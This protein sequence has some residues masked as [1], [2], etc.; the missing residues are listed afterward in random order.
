ME[1]AHLLGLTVQAEGDRL[2]VRGRPTPE[3]ETL[4][5]KLMASKLAV[6]TALA[7]RGQT[8][9]PCGWFCAEPG[10]G[11]PCKVVRGETTLEEYLAERYP[12]TA[13]ADRKEALA[14]FYGHACGL[15]RQARD[16]GLLKPAPP[17]TC[18]HQGAQTEAQRGGRVRPQDDPGFC[19]CCGGPT[20]NVAGLLCKRCS[21]PAGKH[22]ASQ[23]MQN[24]WSSSEGGQGCAP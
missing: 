13:D 15:F 9:C 14:D 1:R 17:P 3:A 6:L 22:I 4:V 20:A 24:G 18:P 16:A 7:L 2:K 8:P 11:L 19:Y 23:M 5:V 21:S 10:L 12:D